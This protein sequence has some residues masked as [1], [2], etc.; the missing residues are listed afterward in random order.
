[1]KFGILQIKVNIIQL[2]RNFQILPAY[3]KDGKLFELEKIF[4]IIVRPKEVL[5]TLKRRENKT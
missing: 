4:E 1:M 3:D 2:I 5:V